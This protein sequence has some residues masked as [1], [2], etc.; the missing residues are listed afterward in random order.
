M[1][2]ANGEKWYNGETGAVEVEKLK[3]KIVEFEDIL[4]ERNK[5]ICELR[6]ELLT[7]T[8]RYWT[9]SFLIRFLEKIEKLAVLTKIRTKKI[10][11]RLFSRNA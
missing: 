3:K 5:K 10:L 11:L 1:K 6:T 7:K 2:D 9:I 8:L 4:L